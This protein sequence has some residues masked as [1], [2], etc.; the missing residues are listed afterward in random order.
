MGESR[1]RTTADYAAK[2]R[3]D[4]EDAKV[5][6]MNQRGGFKA[7]EITLSAKRTSVRNCYDRQKCVYHQESK[8][9]NIS[10]AP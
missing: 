3:Q 6:R 1:R 5:Y 7:T 4:D 9:Y 2:S 10:A 8:H